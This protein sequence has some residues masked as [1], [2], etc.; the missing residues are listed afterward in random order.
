MSEEEE[1]ARCMQVYH[2]I[3]NRGPLVFAER[4][5]VE[6]ATA[7]AAGYES[8]HRD[9][10]QA[11]AKERADAFE[12]G[13]KVSAEEGASFLSGHVA[14]LQL[15]LEAAKQ[16]LRELRP[17]LSDRRGELAACKAKLARVEAA[18]SSAVATIDTYPVPN[19]DQPVRAYI[20]AVGRAAET[21]RAALADSGEKT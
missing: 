12:A 15:Q 1:R 18:I 4:L 13:R 19:D 21:L 17:V 5:S 20:I 3:W 2:E 14:S 11:S 6:L 16:E 10:Y 8:G 9:G 7:R